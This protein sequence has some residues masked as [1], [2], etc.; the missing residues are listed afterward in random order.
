MPVLE[1][2][3]H[4]CPVIAADAT[5]LPEVVGAAGVLCDPDDVDG[6]AA[7]MRSLAGDADRRAWLTEAGL[8]RVGHYRWATS[9]EALHDAYLRA[10]TVHG[11]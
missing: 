6:W 5:A 7:A 8:E 2:M 9:A 1:A 10:G 4:G 3:G 11:R